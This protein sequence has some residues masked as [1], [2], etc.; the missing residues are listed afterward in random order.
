MRRAASSSGCGVR[1][2]VRRAVAAD[3]HGSAFGQPQPSNHRL[4]EARSLVGDDSPAQRVCF[5]CGQH[6]QHLVEHP[7]LTG[8]SR[9]VALEKLVA[10]RDKGIILGCY[11]QRNA[12]HAARAAPNHRP[13]ALE[14]QRRQATMQ[15]ASRCRHRQDRAHCRQGCRRGRKAPQPACRPAHHCKRRPARR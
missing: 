3:H 4:R 12:D 2:G 14:R 9:L 15:R 6:R 10:Q 13:E 5:Q 11:L 1:F 7:T 8:Q